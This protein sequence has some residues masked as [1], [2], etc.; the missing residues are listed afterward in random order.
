M[1]CPNTRL[2]ALVSLLTACGSEPKGST[3]DEA[4]A[5]YVP[6]SELLGSVSQTISASEGGTLDVEGVTLEVPAGAL[7]DDVEI[8]MSVYAPD[9]S[10]PDFDLTWGNVVL[11]EPHGLHFE[12]PLVLT[13]PAPDPLPLE[14]VHDRVVRVQGI[15]VLDEVAGEWVPELGGSTAGTAG[16]LL[17]HFSARQWLYEDDVLAASFCSTVT[18][19]IGELDSACTSVGGTPGASYQWPMQF[20]STFLETMRYTPFGAAILQDCGELDDPVMFGGVYCRF[21]EPVVDLDAVALADAVDQRLLELG[22]TPRT[23]PTC[24][25]DLAAYNLTGVTTWTAHTDNGAGCPADD[26][27]VAAFFE[28]FDDGATPCTD[29]IADVYACDFE[30]VCGDSTETYRIDKSISG[31]L[32]EGHFDGTFIEEVYQDSAL[33]QTCRW[34]L[35]TRDEGGGDG[36]GGG[37][38]GGGDDGG[39]DPTEFPAEAIQGLDWSGHY[40]WID[41]NGS[42]IIWMDG[43][44]AGTMEILAR[45]HY[46]SPGSGIYASSVTYT[47][48]GANQYQIDDADDAYDMVCQYCENGSTAGDCADLEVWALADGLSGQDPS[49]LTPVAFEAL[50][51]FSGQGLVCWPEDGTHQLLPPYD[52]VMAFYR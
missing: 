24:E 20:Y 23:E 45:P 27:I 52:T 38:D 39:T 40:D 16:A 41:D 35:S 4:S 25:E 36:G 5:Y 30:R 10:V 47:H 29:T 33:T 2:V 34:T 9:D 3:G 43:A 17:E 12:T 31:T 1:T 46:V 13:T 37:D 50:T 32:V 44:G 28:S 42:F 14:E 6:Q 8:T 19:G 18:V 21:S 51:S 7:A 15:A 22:H 49:T 48:I 11:L 26:T